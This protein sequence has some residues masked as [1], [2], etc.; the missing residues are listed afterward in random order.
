M[1][2]FLIMSTVCLLVMAL[3]VWCVVYTVDN[4]YSNEKSGYDKYVG[5][6]V[7]IQ[8]DTLKVVDYSIWRETYT[9]SN[10]TEVARKLVEVSNP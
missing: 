4:S 8:K 9:L 5:K 3:L 6:D 10:G 7:V 1:K 2:K